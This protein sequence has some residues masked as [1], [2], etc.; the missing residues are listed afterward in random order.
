MHDW[1]LKTEIEAKRG[2]SVP[3]AFQ[4]SMGGLAATLNVELRSL[5]GSA[6][7]WTD[8]LEYIH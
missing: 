3:G 5:L 7:R 1:R 8:G 2:V 4:I 6:A